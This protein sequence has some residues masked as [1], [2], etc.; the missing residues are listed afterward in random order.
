MMRKRR[1][2][3]TKKT[4]EPVEDYY[5]ALDVDDDSDDED[6]TKMD[7]GRGR[8]RLRPWDFETEDQWEK[9]N[10]QKEANPKAAFQFGIKMK[11]GRKTKT[12]KYRTPEEAERAKERRHEQTF[13]KQWQQIQQIIKKR[14]V[15]R[16][17]PQKGGVEEDRVAKRQKI[18]RGFTAKS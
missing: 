11:D 4:A 8:S 1:R 6:L 13:N 16:G 10:Y 2:R 5:P 12:T 3:R 7:Q 17:K 18:L 15:A 9:Y 14:E